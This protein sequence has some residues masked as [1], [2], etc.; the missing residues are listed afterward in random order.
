M[1]VEATTGLSPREDAGNEHGVDPHMW[2]DP[3]LVVTY[4]E[5]IRDGL[6]QID[7]EGSETYKSNANAIFPNSKI[8]MGGSW[9]R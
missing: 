4:V 6:I 2:L 3:N 9:N 1:I 7:P 8:W 5:N